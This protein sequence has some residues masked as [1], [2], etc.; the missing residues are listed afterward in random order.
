MTKRHPGARRTQQDHNNDPDDIFLARVL[1]TGQWARAN[2]QLLTIVGVVVAIVVAGLVYYGGYQ[3]QLVQQAAQELELVHQSIALQ[4][5]E[6]ARNGLEVFLERFGGTAYEGEARLLLGDL[7]LQSDNPQQAQVILEPL[8]GSPRDP[9]EF[10]GAA[11]LGAAYEQENRWDD[12]EAVYLRIA[13]RADL[14]FQVRNA[15]QSAARIRAD[16]GDAAGAIELYERVLSDMEE[17]DIDRGVFE[18]RIEELK[19][20]MSI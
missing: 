19:T 1:N 3:D 17:N 4:D 6:G 18:M 12:A 8:G 15:L 5:R 20:A 16:N 10:Q 14:S 11:L 2:Q 13:D 9:I 7:Y